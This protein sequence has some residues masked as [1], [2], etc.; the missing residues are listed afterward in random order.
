[1][2]IVA[3]VMDW[4]SNGEKRK[5]SRRA[6]K[7]TRHL[8]E[9]SVKNNLLQHTYAFKGER[10]KRWVIHGFTASV[11]VWEIL[12]DV[13]HT[14]PGA[15]Q[16]IQISGAAGRPEESP[17]KVQKYTTK[18]AVTQCYRRQLFGHSSRYCNLQQNCVRCAGN[19]RASE[20]DRGKFKP[21]SLENDHGQNIRPSDC[22]PPPPPSQEDTFSTMDELQNLGKE[23]KSL[24]IGNLLKI[25]RNLVRDLKNTES[26]RDRSL[27][28][29]RVL[30]RT[31]NMALKTMTYNAR[32][33]QRQRYSEIID[34]IVDNRGD[35]VAAV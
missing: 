1:M 13:R 33:M 9:L 4:A 2:V 25:L 24:N 20:C 12:E 8:R 11:P 34:I 27:A 6:R 16:V 21:E 22:P 35:V 26:G 5:C 18:E 23:V 14:I 28:Q 17:P 3:H 10:R 7:T 19:H 32:G 30:V 29:V 31:L 15:I